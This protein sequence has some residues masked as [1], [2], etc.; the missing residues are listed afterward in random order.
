MADTEVMTWVDKQKRWMKKYR[1]KTYSVSCR[2]L[3]SGVG[4]EESRAAANAWWA[5]KEAELSPP[6]PVV[7]PAE[8]E[9]WEAV[10]LTDEESWMVRIGAAFIRLY[11]EG[12][13][14]IAGEAREEITPPQI[15]AE[16]P[17]TVL[18]WHLRC[19]DDLERSGRYW[20]ETK[21]KQRAAW[22]MYPA[23][24]DSDEFWE[25]KPTVRDE[26]E[27]ETILI[28][29][30]FRK[31]LVKKRLTPE[32]GYKKITEDEV[33]EALVELKYEITWDDIGQ[34][35]EL[36]KLTNR[37]HQAQLILYVQQ[38]E[39][40]GQTPEPTPPPEPL[41]TVKFLEQLKRYSEEDFRAFI[42]GKNDPELVADLVEAVG[43]QWWSQDGDTRDQAVDSYETT[44]LVRSAQ[45]PAV[46]A[47]KPQ[48]P[49]PRKPPELLTDELKEKLLNLSEDEFKQF[50]E[51]RGDAELII[52]IKDLTGREDWWKKGKT[53]RMA[54]DDY[55]L[56]MILRAKQLEHQKR[57]AAPPV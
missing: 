7:E 27:L 42:E 6:E 33:T 11:T 26:R 50:I 24:V 29:K 30:A 49:K 14:G 18:P 23:A 20:F 9:V 45:A 2:Q 3:K 8:Q 25:E 57:T 55:K 1:G 22:R 36:T 52:S 37:W 4:R 44:L 5:A 47:V 46:P 54:V 40:E 12:G 31:V 16:L 34:V 39:S 48:P 41:P 10:A 56:F 51:D 53:R 15:R 13:Y 38:L 43:P 19:R 28:G 32:E 35:V 21:Q 17:P